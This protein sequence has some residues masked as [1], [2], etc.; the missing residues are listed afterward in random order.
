M[1]L[2]DCGI[3]SD[4]LCLKRAEDSGCHR[5]NLLIPE[6]EIEALC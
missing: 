6:S 4:H 3:L 5:Q 2:T 1:S